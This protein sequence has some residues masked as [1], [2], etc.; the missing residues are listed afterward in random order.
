[1]THRLLL[2]L[3]GV[4]MHGEAL[5]AFTCSCFRSVL[6][7]E[8]IVLYIAKDLRHETGNARVLLRQGFVQVSR[9][10]AQPS[11][12]YRSPVSLATRFAFS[13]ADAG[14]SLRRACK[15]ASASPGRPRE[16]W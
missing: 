2:L 10:V 1:M 15:V 13:P 3:L 7:V 6:C 14:C 16:Q 8:A 12:W 5:R 4:L 11:A 9:P